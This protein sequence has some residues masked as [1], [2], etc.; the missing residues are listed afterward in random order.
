MSIL[1][2]K[3]VEVLLQQPKTQHEVSSA[4]NAN[5]RLAPSRQWGNAADALEAVAVVDRNPQVL[6]AC[7]SYSVEWWNL[8]QT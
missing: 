8:Q 2:H 7:N 1:S 5:E 3:R 6:Q 4:A